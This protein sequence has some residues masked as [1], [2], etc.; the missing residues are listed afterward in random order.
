MSQSYDLSMF[1][2]HVAAVSSP[3]SVHFFHDDCTEV[4][5]LW[6]RSSGVGSLL[7]FEDRNFWMNLR[8]GGPHIWE[9]Y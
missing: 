7:A 9:W 1:T 3:S 4:M 2:G 8:F 5:S 6:V